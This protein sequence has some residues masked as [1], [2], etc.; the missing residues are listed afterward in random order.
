MTSDRGETSPD[1]KHMVPP[2]VQYYRTKWSIPDPFEIRENVF[3]QNKLKKCL[4]FL[5]SSQQKLFSLI[6]KFFR[7]CF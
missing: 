1:E 3:V 5:S 6:V 4:I 2:K 7:Q